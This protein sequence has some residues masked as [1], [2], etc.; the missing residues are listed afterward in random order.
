MIN[1]QVLHFELEPRRPRTG[2][3]LAL[4]ITPRGGGTAEVEYLSSYSSEINHFFAGD[5]AT[6]GYCAGSRSFDWET[7][8]FLT[9]ATGEYEKLLDNFLNHDPGVISNRGLNV[10]VLVGGIGTGKSTAIEHAWERLSKAPRMC[11]KCAA[12]DRTCRIAPFRVDLNL[13]HEGPPDDPSLT[14]DEKIDHFWNTV[15]VKAEELVAEEFDFEREVAFWDWCLKNGSFRHRS[16]TLHAWLAA[17]EFLIRAAMGGPSFLGWDRAAVLEALARSREVLMRDLR[18]RDLAWYRLLQVVFHSRTSP[19]FD[20]RCSYIFLDNVDHHDPI[21]Q[22]TAVEFVILLASLMASRAVIAIRPYTWQRAVHG[23]I[24]IPAE[25]HYSPSLKDVL[26][27]RLV[28]FE[29][30]SGCPADVIEAV[31]RLAQILATG[32]P[33]V[34]TEMF[35]ATSGMSVR[36]ALKHFANLTE[37]HLLPPI[38]R[39]EPLDVASRFARAFFYGNAGGLS[40]DSFDN[41]YA[42][43]GDMRAEFRLVKA[44]ILDFLL[45]Q[46]NL[47]SEVDTVVSYMR[48]FNYSDDMLSNAIIDLLMRARPLLWCR[49]G[50]ESTNLDSHSRIAATPIGDGYLKTLFGE[51]YYDEVCIAQT[52]TAHVDVNDV[53]DFHRELWEQEKR[54]IAYAIA[55]RGREFYRSLY[56]KDRIALTVV[57]SRNMQKGVDKRRVSR[58]PLWFDPQR[59][60]YLRA[61]VEAMLNSSGW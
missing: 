42:I 57:H 4:C 28:D 27:T 43:R 24:L 13:G 29:Q 14:V 35:E 48:G 16:L 34:W 31:R 49:D 33:S 17:S 52:P 61:E 23:Q 26:T 8:S 50:Y 36:L 25:N 9:I 19:K 38:G 21:V 60:E 15:A 39:F 45:R 47:V 54:E 46:P 56:P 10:L 58:K 40:S 7:G 11:S 41:L 18:T 30:H 22:Q 1:R 5:T 6:A 3:I 59:D 32:H 2:R 51:I 20:C 53:F 55:N 37:S 44:R 12:S